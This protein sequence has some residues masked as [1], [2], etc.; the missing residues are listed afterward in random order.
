MPRPHPADALAKSL[1]QRLKQLRVDKRLRQAEVAEAARRLG[2]NWTSG[3]V[4]SI[5]TGMR[6][7]A[8]DELLVLPEVL[9]AVGVDGRFDDVIEEWK[10]IRFQLAQAVALERWG[11][12]EEKMWQQE[13]G[14]PP[15]YL[16]DPERPDLKLPRLEP[17][18]E[19][20][21][22]WGDGEAELAAARTFDVHPRRI[23]LRAWKRWQCSLTEERDRRVAAQVTSDTDRSSIQAARGHATRVLLRELGFKKPKPGKRGTR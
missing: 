11:Q 13:V 3:T 4:G 7:L 2:L 23:A 20:I 21:E 18:P 1:G 9:A 17:L 8:A 22:V 5:E 19:L 12:Q 16:P 15:D 14:H 6:R 10:R